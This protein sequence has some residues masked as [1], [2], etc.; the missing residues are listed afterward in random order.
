MSSAALAQV[1]RALSEFSSAECRML[2][3]EVP[4]E[5]LH[6]SSQDRRSGIH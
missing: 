5:N 2:A 4:T 1:K 6:P 3:E